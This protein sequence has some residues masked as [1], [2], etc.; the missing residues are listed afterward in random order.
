MPAKFEKEENQGG[1]GLSKVILSRP[2]SNR[3]LIMANLIYITLVFIAWM[4]FEVPYLN[5][6]FSIFSN[7]FLI[8]GSS[9]MTLRLRIEARMSAK[10]HRCLD[11]EIL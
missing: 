11:P 6:S 1:K 5:E 3:L 2:I 9:S 8:T 7:F 10:K 4:N